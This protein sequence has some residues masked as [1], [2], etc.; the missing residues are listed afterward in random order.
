MEIWRILFV[1]W[2]RYRR[3]TWLCWWGPFILRH[4]STMFG[5]Y[6]PYG[7]WNNDVCNISSN[8]NS[9][10]EVY[11][12]PMRNYE[13]ILRIINTTEVP[14]GVQYHEQCYQKFAIKSLLKRVKKRSEKNMESL[15]EIIQKSDSFENGENKPKRSSSNLSNSILLPNLC[16]FCDKEIR[17]NPR[18]PEQLLN[19]RLNK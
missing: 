8:S 12:W 17:Y 5:V 14:A 13:P 2:P 1:T 18:K 6:R 11:K 10:A 4:H 19:A 15:P 9:N 16:I 3:V 7:T